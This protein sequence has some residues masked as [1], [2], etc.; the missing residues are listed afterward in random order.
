MNITRRSLAGATAAVLTLPLWLSPA[1]A[2]GMPLTFG[3]GMFQ[4]D[5]EKNDATYRPLAQH[6]ASRLGRPVQL[7]TVDSWEGL[8]KSL[9]N[10]ETDIALMGPCWPTISPMRRWCPPS[11]IKASQS[12]LP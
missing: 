9:A 3:V 1:H 5:R 10:G 11:C 2:Q 7:R 12:T 8:A 4:P 6:L